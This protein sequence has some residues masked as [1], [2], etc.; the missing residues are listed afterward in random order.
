MI[1]SERFTATWHHASYTEFIQ[2]MLPQLLAERLPLAGYTATVTAPNS[3]D[4]AVTLEGERGS[5]TVTYPNLP[6]PDAEGVFHCNGV[7]RT[8]VPLVEHSAL[9]SAEVSCVGDLL[10]DWIAARLGEVTAELPWDET[11]LRTV[12]PLDTWVADFFQ[13]HR[14]AQALDMTN[15]LARTCHLRRIIVANPTDLITSDQF[16]RVD[17]FEMPEGPNLGRIFTLA[18]GATIEEGEI[19]IEDASP[20]AALGST[21]IMIPCLEHDDPNRLLMGA[22][23][24]RQWLPYT[25]PEPALVQS[26]NEPDAPHF[27]CGRNLLT[28]YIPAGEDTFEDGI[29]LSESAAKR[30]SNRDHTK[31]P[32]IGG[33]P[34]DLYHE[35]ATG[36]KLSNRHGTKGVVCR[37]LPDEAMP[38]MADGSRV[39][40][41]YSSLRLPGRM[42]P[43]QLWE[44]V[45]GRLAR[46]D[47]APVV[48]APFAGQTEAEIRERLAAAGLPADGME[49]LRGCRN[50]YATSS[51]VGWV[52][53]G[54]TNHLAQDKIHVSVTPK[55]QGQLMGELDVRM[56]QQVGAT[57][58]V[59]EHFLTRAMP[60]AADGEHLDVTPNIAA[61]TLWD[62]FAA[63]WLA[64]PAGTTQ[65]Y[66]QL[67]ARLAAAGIGLTLREDQLQVGFTP[68]D[69]ERLELAQPIPH[70]WLPSRQL[71]ELSADTPDAASMAAYGTVVKANA[72]LAQLLTGATPESLRQPAITQLQE[73]VTAYL[74]MLLQP[75]HLHS[76]GRALFT[77][78]AVL[79]SGA[80]YRHDQIGLPDE[81]AWAFFGPQVAEQL[82]EEAVAER[83]DYAAELL[84][85]ILSD[86]WV[87][88]HYAPTVEPTAFL[89]FRP[90]RIEEAVVRLPSL[91]CPLLNCDF[92]GDQVAIHLP[93]TEAGQREAEERLS[94]AAHLRRDPSLLARLTKQDEA[95]WGLAH[96]SL[97]PAGRAEIEKIVGLPIAMPAGFLTR[98]ALVQALEAQLPEQGTAAVLTKLYAL[99][100]MG[101][102]LASTTGFSL[103]PF[104]GATL[105]LPPAPAADSEA[106]IEQYQAQIAEQLLVGSTFDDELGPYRLGI[107]SGANRE[108]H[109]RTLLHI[110]GV[111]R[112]VRDLK[113]QPAVVRNGFR[114]GL[115][116]DD[117]RKIV[118][119]AR[120]GMARIWLQWEA[121]NRPSGDQHAR[122]S[123]H[124]L[125]RARRA[126]HPGIVFAQAAASGEVD[127]LTDKETRLF[128]GL[129]V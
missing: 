27:W 113:G 94:I 74:H 90:N 26:G 8:V 114:A 102:A 7:E 86:V 15:W 79:A 4:I 60:A 32:W 127:P 110:L 53:W 85:E 106:E 116:L 75:H 121:D 73:S 72:K 55:A 62:Q 39:E 9:A 66:Q 95:I 25:E 83:S 65:L 109:L 11:L 33:Q 91:A 77:G 36:D 78:R 115:A 61:A 1:A 70:P 3:C 96:H 97:T 68:V 67:Q 101:F 5:A 100:Q 34:F 29:I 22:N 20:E 47:G 129:P 54:R 99:I 103:S 124:L 104:V 122:N 93:V 120:A 43:G 92:D 58:F 64:E 2:E 81:L 42:N 87:L 17:P 105:S 125:A 24:M 128:V 123:F 119:G 37:I 49:Q 48:A 40:L 89:A 16:G 126:A 69:G 108:V 45:L 6:H 19:L 117:Y 57:A 35:V 31:V 59:R 98:N 111:P 112:V 107:K 14:H 63:G 30:L 28:A 50:P 76:Q 84:D 56:L 44:A 10:A 82:G 88:L 12:L 80:G 21:S 38:Q 52:Y 51:L 41:I 18:L 13:N 71:T 118:P 46:H 23:M